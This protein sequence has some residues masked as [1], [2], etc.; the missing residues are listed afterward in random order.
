MQAF[1]FFRARVIQF[2]VGN[3][4]R[5]CKVNLG[6]FTVFRGTVSIDA[7]P[8]GLGFLLEN[9]ATQIPSLRDSRGFW[10]LQDFR[11]GYGS[12]ANRT[13]RAWEPR[14]DSGGF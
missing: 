1:V 9:A 14:R 5:K 3:A 6:I 10:S 12:V 11:V 4:D 13:Y 8:T 7:A 2:S